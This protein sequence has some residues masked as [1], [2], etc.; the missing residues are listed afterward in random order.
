MHSSSRLSPAL[1]SP[2]FG[3]SVVPDV[4]V[5]YLRPSEPGFLRAQILS[6][7]TVTLAGVKF[8]TLLNLHPLKH[9]YYVISHIPLRVKVFICY[10]L[11]LSP[12]LYSLAAIIIA[13]FVSINIYITKH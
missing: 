11:M 2:F 8:G 4:F 7:P 10:G 12:N 13:C 5:C 6:L 1:R 3:V 9:Q